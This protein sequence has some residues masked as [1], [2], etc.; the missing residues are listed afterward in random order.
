MDEVVFSESEA[1]PIVVGRQ[2]DIITFSDSEVE[3]IVGNRP[4]PGDVAL[5]FD[6]RGEWEDRDDAGSAAHTSEEVEPLVGPPRHYGSVVVFDESEVD[7]I[8]GQR[9]QGYDAIIAPGQSELEPAESRSDHSPY[10]GIVVLQPDKGPQLTQTP[11]PGPYS[12]IT[13]TENEVEEI[14]G[15]RQVTP[16]FATVLQALGV[17][18]PQR[19]HVPFH[20]DT[21]LGPSGSPLSRGRISFELEDAWGL[22]T[23][24]DV[25]AG[26]LA[27]LKVVA[28][29]R[30]H[31]PAI[32]AAEKRFRVDR[33]AIAGAIAWEALENIRPALESARVR[34]LGSSI[35]P[36]KVH[37]SAAAIREAEQRG[38]VPVRTD[39]DRRR[40]L[41]TPGGAIESIAGIMASHADV[42]QAHGYDIRLNPELLTNEYHGRSASAFDKVLTDNQVAAARAG[43]RHVP[44]AG[45]EMALWLGRRRHYIETAVGLPDPAVLPGFVLPA[46]PE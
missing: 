41:A 23:P 35:G 29:L 10:Q 9:S 1:D 33:R 27:E 43:R 6:P 40:A 19:Q 11:N 8:I 14:E 32:V 20:G 28:W 18:A 17:V 7:P 2:T 5:D 26:T 4:G 42:A 12:V 36:G 16:S 22:P 13:F 15:E 25:L 37:V 34:G 24:R 39:D 3:P 30:K 46:P 31:L 45:N 44:R 21:P 38:Y